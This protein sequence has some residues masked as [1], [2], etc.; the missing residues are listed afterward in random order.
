MESEELAAQQQ[1]DL[2]SSLLVKELVEAS[3]NEVSEQE[4]E[5]KR[6][7][8]ELRESYLLNLKKQYPPEVCLMQVGGVPG[9]AKGDL[10]AI[11]AKQKQGK[12]HAIA[13][14]IAVLLGC[15]KFRIRANQEKKIKILYFDTEQ[16][17]ADTQEIYRGV[18]RLAGLPEE[19]IHDYLQFWTIEAMPFGEMFDNV[20]FIIEEE[21]PDMVII[22]GFIDLVNDFN[23][24]AASKQFVNEMR[25]LATTFN[26]AI[27]GV[28]HTNK[29]ADDHNMRGHVG[30]MLAQKSALVL[31][32]TKSDS[33]NVTVKCTDSRKKPLPEWS[34]TWDDDGNL[35]SADEAYAA[36]L[37]EEALHKHEKQEARKQKQEDAKFAP[38]KEIL[39]HHQITMKRSELAQKLADNTGKS[40]STWSNHI[41][42]WIE[43]GKLTV[44]GDDSVMLS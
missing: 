31:E 8:K 13:V 34:F 44:V 43:T 29:A 26:C 4:A 35:I 15:K 24:L 42:H 9:F 17:P 10:A 20:K 22:D 38:V 2:S 28:L 19:D 23:D 27:V 5:R 36:E 21:K 41:S 11:K 32:C 37:A 40:R 18:F 6:R 14:I 12:T 7:L 39:K 25:S 16:K 30:T 33:N 1:K 3:A